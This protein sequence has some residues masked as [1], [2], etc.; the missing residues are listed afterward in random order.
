MKLRSLRF[1]TLLAAA[2][3][4][5]CGGDSIVHDTGTRAVVI[6]I[7]GADWKIIEALAEDGGMPNLMALRQRGAWGPI[8]TLTEKERAWS[9]LRFGKRKVIPLVSK[10]ERPELILGAPSC[11]QLDGTICFGTW[12]ADVNSHAACITSVW[13]CMTPL[14]LPVEPEV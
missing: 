2:L 9:V 12:A 4:A 14:G 11:T 8:A 13:A 3:L 5:A 6:G 1:A 7:D 10:K